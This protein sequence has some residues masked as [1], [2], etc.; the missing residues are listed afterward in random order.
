M[1]RTLAIIVVLV[2]AVLFIVVPASAQGVFDTTIPG[3]GQVNVQF[4]YSRG[5]DEM[6]GQPL[7]VFVENRGVTTPFYIYIIM[8]RQSIDQV[9]F[10]YELRVTRP[11]GTTDRVNTTAG[12]Y[13]LYSGSRTYFH[14]KGPWY[15]RNLPQDGRYFFD[16]FVN[17]VKVA[18]IFLDLR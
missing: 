11:D 5:F 12:T 3:I 9:T 10:N 15:D 1:K 8:D 13:T 14:R 17:G 18:S 4:G 6:N 2:V 16:F 7:G